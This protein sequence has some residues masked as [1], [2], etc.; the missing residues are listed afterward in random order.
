MPIN[1]D[2]RYFSESASRNSADAIRFDSRGRTSEAI[3][4]YERAC[5]ALAVLAR[6]HSQDYRMVK[7]WMERH[8]AYQNRIKA[9]RAKGRA[10][11]SLPWA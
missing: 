7:V 10:G 9:L 2:D 1:N 3:E 6:M 4:C 8:M 11:C 5:H